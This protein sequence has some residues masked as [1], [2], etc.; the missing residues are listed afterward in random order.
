MVPFFSH[1]ARA[2]RILVFS[3]ALI[4][5]A[6]GAAASQKV[7][8]T[9]KF[10]PG[11]TLYYQIESRA[12]TTGKT[13]T[14]IVNP[15]A[16]TRSSQTVSLL[17]RLDVLAPDPAAGAAPSAVRFRATYEQSRAETE[18]DAFDTD[19]AALEDQYRRIEGHA[20]EFTLDSGG[21]ITQI[22]GLE[23]IFP[24]RSAAT[25]VL[26]WL[27]ALFITGLPEQ[28]VA[29]GQK[30]K[31]ERPV[32]SAPLAGLA[33]VTDSAYL[34]D[35]PCALSAR[36]PDSSPA[37]P[38]ASASVCATIL[39]H[40]EVSRHGSPHG[41]ATPP[42][43]L[44]NGLRTSGTWTGSGQS[45]DSI[46]LTSGLLVSST[47]TSTQEMDYQITSASTGSSIHRVGRVQNQSIITLVPA[48]T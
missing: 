47:E 8:F 23:D 42:D 20:F 12:T 9:P 2:F 11:E 1:L 21:Q 24:N 40:F 31:S 3:A 43:Y 32:A 29:V 18:S 33:W 5:F 44:Q 35:E 39:T 34:R 30:W 36:M 13:T 17:I 25:P 26:A 48:K 6:F 7:R 10:F 19:A 46:S 28:G 41:D 4:S 16:G 14:P 27:N 38:Q 45:L 22:K 15:E 37:H